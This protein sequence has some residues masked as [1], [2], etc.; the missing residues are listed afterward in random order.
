M[1][2]VEEDARPTP[3]RR[4][5]RLLAFVAVTL[6]CAAAVRID[7]QVVAGFRDGRCRDRVRFLAAPLR[8]P[9]GADVDAM[10]VERELADLGYRRVGGAPAEPGS[11]RREADRIEIFLR[12]APRPGAWSDR[13]ATRTALRLEGSRVVAIDR[14]DGGPADA[15]ELEPRPLDGVLDETWSPREPFR[16]Q[17]APTHAV[18][19]VLAAEDARFLG[20]PGLDVGSL[21]RALKVNWAA[22][23]VRQGGSTITQQVVK[24]HFLSQE[25][26]FLRKLR[27]IPMAL[28]LE[29]RFGKREILECYLSNVYLGHDGGVGIHGLAEGARVFFGKPVGSLTVGESATLAGIIRSPNALSPL[30]HPAQARARR[31]Q[32]IAQMVD[33]GW[34]GPAQADAA[35]AEPLPKPP[36]RAAPADVFFVQQVRRDLAVRGLPPETMETGTAVFTTLD[37]RLQRAA[38]REVAAVLRRA[39][40]RLPALRGVQAGIV[41][42]DPRDGGVRALVGG[43]DF[44]ASELDHA[45]QARRPVGSL[46]LP[47]AWLAAIA[48]PSSGVTPATRLDGEPLVVRDGD[49]TWTIEDPGRAP[50]GSVSARE[51]MV[52]GLVAP[53][54]RVAARLGFAR[55]AAALR[56]LPFAREPLPPGPAVAT[57]SFEAS[58]LD[59]V[60]SFAAFPGL[61]RI[62]SPTAVAGAKAPAGA[63][64]LRSQPVLA[65]IADPAPI[66]VVH[67][68]FARAERERAASRAADPAR[69]GSPP[70]FVTRSGSSEGL[71][72]QWWVG[73][74][75]SLVLGAWIGFDDDRPMPPP[76]AGLATTLGEAI[77]R[78]GLAGLPAEQVLAP[79]GVTTVE[80]DEASG[81]RAA[82]GC[83]GHV[84]MDFVSGTAPATTCRPV[85]S[86]PQAAPREG[87]AARRPR[88][89]LTR[90]TGRPTVRPP[91]PL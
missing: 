51:A 52:D 55:V 12:A 44:R 33:N 72:D 77:A 66:W 18:D 41:A 82:P 6:L 58:L 74:S 56:S 25:R 60:V 75:P 23:G 26:S 21:L 2:E 17:D 73:W 63:N 53:A 46:V 40:G 43:R 11:F 16:L 84:A 31:D 91:E 19:A 80:I 45:V 61:G 79:E 90:R 37:L 86:R 35:R 87:E 81:L 36:R 70:G 28:A 22:G 38:E 50:R 76:S 3:R 78:L 42:I 13:P 20:H 67:S 9:A 1:R 83:P 68:T 88:R 69:A 62:P 8:I 14:D 48:D 49:E 59:S 64:R 5:G 15:L 39:E 71:R 34:I 7:R 89:A 57:G 85:A 27:E 47:F 24:N 30:R 29:A 10:G 54:A 32:V 4:R 65:R